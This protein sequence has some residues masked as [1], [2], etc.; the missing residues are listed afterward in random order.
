MIASLS[1]GNLLDVLQEGFNEQQLAAYVSWVN[2]QLRKRPGVAP[3]QDLRQDLRDGVVLAHLI[4]IVAGEVLEGIHYLPR[5]VQDSRE[6]V[7]KVLQFV[8]SKQIR[9]PQTSARDIME[10]NL[11]SAMRLILALAAHFKPSASAGHRAAA[12]MGRSQP[13]PSSTN[14]RPHSTMAM[15][16]NA[17]ATLAA[18]RQDASRSGR[19]VLQ[20]RQ[21]W[22]SRKASVDEEIESPCWSVRALVQQY[23]CQREGREDSTE[24]L[25]SSLSSPS[26]T[27]TP[28]A[29]SIVSQSEDKGELVDGQ[30]EETSSKSDDVAKPVSFGPGAAVV[31]A[32][33]AGRCS[34]EDQLC[35]QQEQLEREMHEARRMVSS[36]QALLLHG[37]LPEDE[38]EV[39]LSLGE[40]TENAEQQLVVI[41]SRLDQSM[42]E[43]L[44]LKKELLKYKQESRNLQGVKDALQQRLA[45]QEASVLQLKQELLRSSMAR[46]ELVGQNAELQRKLEDRS[47]QLNEYKKDLGQKERLLQQQ[48]LKLDEA[49]RKLAESSHHKAGLQ[50]ELEHK[51]SLLQELMNH[52]LDEVAGPQNNGYSHLPG[53]TPPLKGAEE[54]QLV[55]DALR[56]LR[57]SFSGHDP[58]HHTLDTLEQGVASLMDRLHAL[59]TRRRPDRR[60]R[61]KSPGRKATHTDRDSWPS[62][63]KM[64]HSHSSPVL[65]ASISTKVLYFTDRSLT[66]FMVNIPKRLG[67]VTLRDF[68]AAVDREGNFRYHFKALDPEFGTVKEEV[69]QDDAVVPGWEGK[70]VAWVE[71]DHGESRT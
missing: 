19:S 69:F 33:P 37:S 47:R 38:Q 24:T 66:P 11:K 3:V 16:Q 58:Q 52:D 63:T 42:E 26:P 1:K 17:M 10:G 23:E 9:M 68:K 46:E 65:N 22:H 70:I 51:E 55:R 62:S 14:H 39:S 2:A 12:A 49:L 8:S 50:R 6:N 45:V 54:L 15:A 35:E 64:A 13:G 4:E 57:N 20:L 40:G 5:D 48:Q 71:E 25:P 53:P 29:E 28:K 27:H 18:A 60:G 41:R 61:G 44:N 43:S 36:L 30:S 21:E 32:G 56:S 7:E 34:W 67:E 31:H 59:D